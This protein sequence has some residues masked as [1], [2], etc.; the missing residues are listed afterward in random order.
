MF[1]HNCQSD[2]ICQDLSWGEIPNHRSYLPYQIR[3]V[4]V[5]VFHLADFL[6]KRSGKPGHKWSLSS[7]KQPPLHRPREALPHTESINNIPIH[8]NS[9][10]RLLTNPKAQ[11][12]LTEYI[13]IYCLLFVNKVFCGAIGQ[14][15]R[16]KHQLTG[17]RKHAE[18]IIFNHFN[19]LVHKVYGPSRQY[20]NNSICLS[21]CL[22]IGFIY[23][24][25]YF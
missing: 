14:L 11:S 15:H 6:Y 20:C 9:G 17:G 7:G 13:H 23:S 16:I 18:D 1:T 4:T 24:S 3:I 8:R 22:Y 25:Q 5:S 10:W 2:K 12:W 21:H 19:I